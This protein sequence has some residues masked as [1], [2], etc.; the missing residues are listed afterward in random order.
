MTR[1]S[2]SARLIAAALVF[3]SFA[4]SLRADDGRRDDDTFLYFIG[5]D[6]WRQG[7]FSH[8][9]LVWSP[10]GIDRDGFTL[11]LLLG[12]GS[13]RYVSGALGGEDVV[14]RQATAFVMPGWRFVRDRTTATLFAGLDAQRHRLFPDDP[15]NG[16]R[17]GHVGL[18]GAVELWHEPDAA[19]M[20]AADASV[21]TVGPS[22]SARAA[23]GWRLFD[24]FYLGPEVGGFAGDDSYRQ[25]R[26]GL[27][28][29]GA[30]F[31]F[32]EWWLAAGFARDSDRNDGLYARF[33]V[34]VRR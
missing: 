13:Y 1:V 21:S 14:G 2:S 8:G 20:W 31:D 6:L 10:G 16:L 7:G 5:T 26:A 29:T 4:G 32:M 24:A 18:R 11:K 30:K 15:G 23:F 33:G 12:T 22:Y 27:H 19:T 34:L 25:L 28:V 3:C 9:G 17:G